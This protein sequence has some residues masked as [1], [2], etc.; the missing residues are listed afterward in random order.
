MRLRRIAPEVWVGISGAWQTTHTVGGPHGALVIDGPVRPAEIAALAARARADMLIATHGDWDHLLA[1]L[2]FPWARRLTGR[3]TI[4]RIQ[5]DAGTIAGELAAWDALQRVPARGLPD[6]AAA[7]ALDAPGEFA[8]AAGPMVLAPTPGHTADGIAVLLLDQEVL[9]AGD[10]LSPC[11]IPSLNSDAGRAAYLASLERL[12]AMIRRAR[13]VVPGHGWPLAAARAQTIL[14]EDRRYV[15][16]LGGAIPPRVP[17]HAADPA[18]Q[19]QHRANLA[20]CGRP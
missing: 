12:E 1:P 14:A 6:W 4:R 2:A 17:R 11:E 15:D 13:C 9:V 5:Q 16:G 7:E 18:Q 19:A 10:Y 20:A 3:A 8:S